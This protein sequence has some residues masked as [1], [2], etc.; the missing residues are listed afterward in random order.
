MLGLLGFKLKRTCSLV[1][2]SLSVPLVLAL[3]FPALVFA[4][5]GGP[6]SPLDPASP[7]AAAIADLHNIVL[8]I[9]VVVFVVVEGLMLIAAFRFR[10]RPQD[11]GEPPQIHGN[12]RLEIAWTVAP[13]LIVVALFVLTVRAQQRIDATAFS[14]QPG[15]PITVEVLGHEW[16]W[17][18]RYPDLSIVT[19]GNLVIPAGRVINLEIT[20]APRNKGRD[21]GVVHSFWVP[22][23]GGKTDAIPGRVNRSW[24]KASAPGEF[25][26]QCAELCGVSHANM[27]LVV[28][29]LSE[30]EFSA[31]A[32]N[33]AQ[34]AVPPADSVAQSGQ[35]IFLNAGCTG[36]HSIGGVSSAPDQIGPNLTHVA[37]RPYIAGGILANTAYNLGRWLE[38]PPAVKPGV[39]MPDLNLTPEQNDTLV[40][41]LQTLK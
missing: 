19:A 12:T 6:P 2:V 36:C 24:L 31:W 20:S 5:P 38:N 32:R 27:R 35:Q 14:D 17:E 18:F 4:Q 15:V 16:W 10:R 30:D 7:A 26:G 23:L 41:Y 1:V 21:Q 11:T 37:D 29:A 13:A 39:L 9:A 28:T 34:A 8:I 22:E 40:A 3:S 33:Q 25:Y